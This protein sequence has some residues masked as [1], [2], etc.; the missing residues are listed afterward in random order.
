M[1]RRISRLVLAALWTEAQLT[2]RYFPDE[3]VPVRSYRC[4]PIQI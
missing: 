1:S 4:R 2:A 3:A